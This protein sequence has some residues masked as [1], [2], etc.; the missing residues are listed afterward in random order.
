MLVT[1]FWRKNAN[2]LHKKTVEINQICPTFLLHQGTL[3]FKHQGTRRVPPAPTGTLNRRCY[4]LLQQGT[5]Q[6]LGCPCSNGV[7]H[8][9]PGFAIAP[10]GYPSKSRIHSAQTGNPHLTL[11]HQITPCTTRYLHAPPGCPNCTFGVPPTFLLPYSH[12]SLYFPSLSCP[13]YLCGVT[14]TSRIS[15]SRS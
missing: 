14:Y 10:T 7:A 3:P 1:Y 2:A 8:Q 5:T 15:G 6:P 11:H 9:P 4:P 12:H 13:G